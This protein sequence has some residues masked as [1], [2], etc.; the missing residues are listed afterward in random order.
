MVEDW[1]SGDW[2]KDAGICSM[3]A[4]VARASGLRSVLMSAD[5]L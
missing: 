1:G 2:L 4:T 5:T 3:Y